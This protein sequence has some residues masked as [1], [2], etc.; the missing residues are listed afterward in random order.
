MSQVME[1]TGSQ[2]QGL[3]FKGKKKDSQ[4]NS[5]CGK[6]IYHLLG[7]HMEKEAKEMKKVYISVAKKCIE[8][9]EIQEEIKIWGKKN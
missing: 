2:C 1:K 8:L 7:P 5:K 9:I 6:K 4:D 3:I